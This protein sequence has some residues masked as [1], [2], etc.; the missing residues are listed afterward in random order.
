MNLCELESEDKATLIEYFRKHVKGP[1]LDIGCGVNATG[2]FIE[3]ANLL[4]IDIDG[5]DYLPREKDTGSVRTYTQG[6]IYNHTLIDG[7]YNTITMCDVTY[8]FECDSLDKVHSLLDRLSISCERFILCFPYWVHEDD[9]TYMF[10]SSLDSPIKRLIRNL[11]S[12]NILTFFP[13]LK[14]ILHQD[15]S[16]SSDGY[17]IYYYE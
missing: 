9:D 4:G 15:E 2:V 6:N 1:I 16:P 14:R 7:D 10:R 5:I 8:I 11:N 17:G 12:K 3:I 13:R